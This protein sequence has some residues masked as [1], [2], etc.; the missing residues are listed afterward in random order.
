MATIS[1]PGI[2]IGATLPPVDVFQSCVLFSPDQID[3]VDPGDGTEQPSS[4]GTI[5]AP[6]PPGV[7]EPPATT[8]Y[9]IV[10]TSPDQLIGCIF[11]AS[12]NPQERLNILFPSAIEGDGVV[13]RITN[14]IWVL[15]SGVW[16][17]VGPTPGPTIVSAAILPPYIETVVFTATSVNSMLIAGEQGWEELETDVTA[18]ATNESEFAK[19]GSLAVLDAVPLEATVNNPT[20]ITLTVIKPPVAACLISVGDVR[21]PEL[22]KRIP[23]A[24]AAVRAIPPFRA[25]NSKAI[26]RQ[27]VGVTVSAPTVQ[28]E[29]AVL[30][31]PASIHVE[32]GAVRIRAGYE[33]NALG[34]VSLVEFDLTIAF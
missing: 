26:P 22:I 18:T 31:P 16:E 10:D 15:R 23:T 2:S 19:I 27:I 1:V 29:Q 13:E 32:A 9:T 5:W 21:R 11:D 33:D 8:S 25:G 34:L 30:P 24:A 28:T 3:P 4:G 20:A 17:N 12:Q 6:L 7:T 14:D